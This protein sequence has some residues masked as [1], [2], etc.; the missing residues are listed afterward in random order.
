MDPSLHASMPHIKIQL[1]LL[2]NVEIIQ[3]MLGNYLSELVVG[4]EAP[5]QNLSPTQNSFSGASFFKKVLENRSSKSATQKTYR[6][7]GS[8]EVHRVVLICS[9]Y[10]TALNTLTQLQLDIL[11]GLCYQNTMLYDLWLFLCSLGP[12][13][14]M[15]AFLD[16]LAFNTKCSAPEFQMLQLFA[17]CMAHYV[18]ILDDMEMYEQQN[19]F[20]LNDFVVM[21]NFLN[22]FLY[23]AVLGNLFD[24]KTI[25]SNPLFQSLHT[26]L[27]L[28]YRRDCRRNYTPAGHWL[29]KDIKV[30]AFMADLEKGRRAPQLLL[31]TMPHIIP[32]ED[33]VRLFREVHSERE[34]YAR[35]NGIGVRL[36]SVYPDYCTQVGV[37]VF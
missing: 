9:L 3:I 6:A 7:L 37:C 34:N 26:L 35:S 2:W 33:R 18:T 8:P 19:P 21:S 4:T 28:L 27:M 23:K 5:F 22:A 1:H 29:V 13:C 16:H 32:H 30:S 14:G 31:Q 11:T 36:S 15:K 10:H 12:N 24:F 17:D 25:Q 20:K